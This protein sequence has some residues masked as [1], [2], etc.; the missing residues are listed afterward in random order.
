MEF[1]TFVWKTNLQI[2]GG[3][4]L[5]CLVTPSRPSFILLQWWFLDL[6]EQKIQKFSMGFFVSV[7]PSA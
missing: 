6:S 7:C 4:M 5:N 1:L 3:R 2:S